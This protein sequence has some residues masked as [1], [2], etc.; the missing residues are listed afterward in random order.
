MP[1]REVRIRRRC[2][3]LAADTGW[4]RIGP[5]SGAREVLELRQ[6]LSVASGEV[7]MPRI[8]FSHNSEPGKAAGAALLRF[9]YSSDGR[10]NA[11]DCAEWGPH[12]LI[13]E[14]T[15]RKWIWFSSGYHGWELARVLQHHDG[16]EL[17]ATNA[18]LDRSEA[19]EEDVLMRRISI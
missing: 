11:L 6:L 2:S 7:R 18:L 3:A 17:E 8:S 14:K 19:G 12:T 10:L 4:R 15:A 5:D 1:S 9:S 16:T 13:S